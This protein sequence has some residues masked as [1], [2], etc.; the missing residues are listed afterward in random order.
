MSPRSPRDGGSYW[1]ACWGSGDTPAGFL[2]SVP[3]R[4]QDPS[5]S[6]SLLSPGALPHA[7]KHPGTL[8]QG[9][10]SSFTKDPFPRGLCYGIHLPLDTLCT[11]SDVEP[12]L[13]H[14]SDPLF[15]TALQSPD[16]GLGCP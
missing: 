12:L 5:F 4:A 11:P 8:Y 13:Q 15:H 1:P 14:M 3:S 10:G 16:E 2:F 9:L 6:L 7:S